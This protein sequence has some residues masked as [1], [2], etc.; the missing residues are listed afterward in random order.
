MYAKI[1]NPRTN[2]KVKINSKL[3]K[4]IIMNYYNSIKGGSD[5]NKDTDIDKLHV[6]II[7][8]SPGPE[9]KEFNRY[10][11]FLEEKFN[12]SEIKKTIIYDF[13]G[14]RGDKIWPINIPMDTKYDI[15]WFCGCNLIGW[16]SK[17]ADPPLYEVL[18]NVLK[19]NGLVLFTEDPKMVKHIK[20]IEITDKDKQNVP[21]VRIELLNRMTLRFPCP[22]NIISEF[23]N[24]FKLSDDYP[25]LYVYQIN[26]EA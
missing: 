15:I 21:S 25:K 22:A 8:S 20:D 2:R 7:C 24:R 13:L 6:L 18:I 3:G 26:R 19:D 1:V 14:G 9:H 10:K 11:D 23:N 5:T 4:L 17:I 16:I 12:N